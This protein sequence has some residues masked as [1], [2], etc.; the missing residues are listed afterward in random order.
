[1]DRRQDWP[2]GDSVHWEI[3]DMVVPFFVPFYEVDN[4]FD[5]E[6]AVAQ[7]RIEKW[8]KDSATDI[9]RADELMAKR[10]EL[11][12]FKASKYG[13][14]WHHEDEFGLMTLVRNDVHDSFVHKGGNGMYKDILEMSR[15]V[16]GKGGDGA[17][18]G[19]VDDLIQKA[20]EEEIKTPM[21]GIGISA[22]EMKEKVLEI[23]SEVK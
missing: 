14:V 20:Y 12:S 19:Q 4:A 15:K 11:P 5:N 21:E 6:I 3:N 18:I 23:I 8:V 9:K 2:L 1:M 16:D 10:L 17:L 22:M 13:Y 7:L